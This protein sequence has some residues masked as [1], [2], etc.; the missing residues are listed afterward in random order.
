MVKTTYNISSVELLTD[1][2]HI[3]G[4]FTRKVRTIFTL[5]IIV[6]IFVKPFL[7]LVLHLRQFFIVRIFVKRATGPDGGLILGSPQTPR[8]SSLIAHSFT[9]SY[10]PVNTVQ[11]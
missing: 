10:A 9:S 4:S 7:I 3:G 8:R 2:T 5:K 11:S 6:S 1:I